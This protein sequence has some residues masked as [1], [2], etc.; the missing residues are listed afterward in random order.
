MTR[1][2]LMCEIDTEHRL[3][4]LAS[5]VIWTLLGEGSNSSRLMRYAAWCSSLTCAWYS[6]ECAFVSSH[7]CPSSVR[8]K[9]PDDVDVNCRFLCQGKEKFG[10]E[11]THRTLTTAFINVS[12]TVQPV[13]TFRA[14]VSSSM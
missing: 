13:V 9:N 14:H 8:T 3:Q 10:F 2:W 11:C 1:D 12:C 4:E 7:R 6:T 5:K